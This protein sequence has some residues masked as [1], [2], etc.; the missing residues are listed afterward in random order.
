MAMTP[1]LGSSTSPSP[2]ISNDTVAS[3]TSS[4]ACAAQEK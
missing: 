1:S 3:A 2:V 4:D